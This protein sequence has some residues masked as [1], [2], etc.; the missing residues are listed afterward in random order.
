MVTEFASTAT[1]LKS[2]ASRVPTLASILGN[3]HNPRAFLMEGA[4][5]FSTRASFVW[6]ISVKAALLMEGTS[7]FGLKEYLRQ[8]SEAQTAKAKCTR[9]VHGITP[10]GKLKVDSG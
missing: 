8:G 1:K 6:A 7:T 9:K 10:T 2:R 3:F 5:S 4:F